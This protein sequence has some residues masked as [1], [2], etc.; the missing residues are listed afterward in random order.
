[1]IYYRFFKKIGT[2]IATLIYE[3]RVSRE[4]AIKNFLTLKGRFVMKKNLIL[5]VCF[6]LLLGIPAMADALNYDSIIAFG[7]AKEVNSWSLTGYTNGIDYI[8]KTFVDPDFD[9]EYDHF[10]FIPPATNPN[11]TVLSFII[12]KNKNADPEPW[13]YLIAQANNT[14]DWYLFYNDHIVAGADTFNIYDDDGIITFTGDYIWT[15]PQSGALISGYRDSNDHGGIDA[16]VWYDEWAFTFNGTNSINQVDI[17]IW[18]PGETPQ[19]GECEKDGYVDLGGGKCCDPDPNSLYLIW[20]S[21]SDPNPAPEPGSILLLGT[22]VIGLGFAA[23][24]KLTK[25]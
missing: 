11:G 10:N 22:G 24:R 14:G 25:K 15:M 19:T 9:G 13:T 12:A 4:T 21:C 7:N 3:N 17:T 23:R 2:R 20:P 5:A 1:M 8:M 6:T 18:Y 16:A